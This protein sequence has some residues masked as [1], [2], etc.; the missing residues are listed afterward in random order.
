M[1]VAVKNSDAVII[2]SEIIP[3]ELEAYLNKLE[4]PVLKYHNMDDFS[5]AYLDFYQ[6]KVLV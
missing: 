1:K 4:K 5:Q 6:T 2:G 3:D